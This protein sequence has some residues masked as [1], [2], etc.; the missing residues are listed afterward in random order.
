MPSVNFPRSAITIPE[1]CYSLQ[2]G[3]NIPVV[4]DAP[5]TSATTVVVRLNSGNA[6]LMGGSGNYPNLLTTGASITIPANSLVGYL[7]FT[8]APN[9]GVASQMADYVWEILSASGGVTVGSVN[10][11]SIAVMDDD[12]NVYYPCSGQPFV[13]A[14]T[15]ESVSLPYDSATSAAIIQGNAYGTISMNG[16]IV[17]VQSNGIPGVVVI[18]VTNANGT[19]NS[20]IVFQ[21]SQQDCAPVT[22]SASLTTLSC[23]QT[24]NLTTGNT[25]GTVSWSVTPTNLGTLASST[26]TTNQFTASASTVTGTAVITIEDGAGKTKSISITVGCTASGGGGPT[27]GGSGGA[28]CGC[29][30]KPVCTGYVRDCTIDSCGI[31]DLTR[32][33]GLYFGD[34]RATIHWSQGWSVPL[35]TAPQKIYAVPG[36]MPEYVFT[37]DCDETVW[38]QIIFHHE[39]Q[40]VFT[41]GTADPLSD[42]IMVNGVAIAYDYPVLNAIGADPRAYMSLAGKFLALA[43][44]E[45]HVWA[46]SYN[47]VA[48]RYYVALRSVTIIRTPYKAG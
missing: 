30:D 40:G 44:Q 1:D 48:A 3:F 15:C 42:D 28:G 38:V 8:S 27:N 25:T 6:S 4:L 29:P 14:L 47:T 17:T 16:N 26:G 46:Q 37:P 41:P 43:G 2:N 13:D 35:T 21:G 5:V 32:K 7:H 36:L 12:A 39:T 23:G 9:D 31:R 19:S 45:Y 34:P 24:T 22:L 10:V 20:V 33:A 18:A 11:M